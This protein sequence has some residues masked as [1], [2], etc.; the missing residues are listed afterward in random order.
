[1][2]ILL[3]HALAP[4]VLATAV[5]DQ[6]PPA[7]VPEVIAESDL[8][9]A[10]RAAD[11]AEVYILRRDIEF[12]ISP[13][14]DTVRVLGCRYMIHREDSTAWRELEAALADAA[15]RIEPA[16]ASGE[17]RVGL[18]LSDRR[19]I[20]FEAYSRWPSGSEASVNGLSQRRQVQ[21]SA[22]FATELERVAERHRDLAI[23]IV[24]PMPV[25]A[26]AR[27]QGPAR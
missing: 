27:P 5:V 11:V 12:V 20:L 4:A 18:V 8:M 17:V 10:L 6:T 19:G 14:P 3:L 7:R 24:H 22:S 1:M 23:P 2:H 13:S 15:I 9:S 25:C 26:P 16:E 21:V